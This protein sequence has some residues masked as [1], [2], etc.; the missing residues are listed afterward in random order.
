M[1]S[2]LRTSYTSNRFYLVGG[3][4]AGLFLLGHFFAPLLYI[5]RVLLLVYLVL[6]VLDLLMIYSLKNGVEAVRVA[7]DKLSNGDDNSIRIELH[8][9]YSF[10]VTGG[11]VDEIP[12]QFQKRD[13][14]FSY[15]IK[16]GEEKEIR[17]TLHPV[18]R[19]VYSFGAVNVFAS[20]PVGFFRR[21]YRYDY[22]KEVAV[23]PSY[24]Q[25]RKYELLA[26]S[27]QLVDS[28]IKKIRRIGHNMEFEQI[29]DYVP[30]DDFRTI[31]W[32][33][34]ARR[35]QLMVNNYTDER[36]QHIYA[37]IDKGR[38]MKSP[39]KGMTL[40]DYAINASLAITNIA[41]KKDDK[42]GLVTYESTVDQIIPA[43][44]RNVQMKLINEALYHQE[45][46]FMESDLGRV[47]VQ[48]LRK[49]NQ[50]SLLLFFTNFE[51]IV[52]MERQLSHLRRLAHSHLVV[53]IFFENTE[54]T[55]LLNST[56]KNLEQ[57]YIK[58]IGE[59]FVLEKKQIVKELNKIGVHAVLTPPE[60][61]TVQTVNKY[62]ELK[63]RGLI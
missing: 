58:T 38:L 16:A 30:G 52:S 50:R 32:K 25:M 14:N 24:I 46:S 3:A 57:V 35:S 5:G 61:L 49:L 56:P 1:I 2:F 37:V 15:S 18:K 51:S 44:K 9:Y 12:H 39:F 20:G 33:A 27:N 59:K 62:L 22:G 23:Y 42:A 29:K 53:C 40:L 4:L 11:I 19:G 8:N 36:S 26:I 45:T 54:L 60:N 34:T 17:Y 43:S 47:T 13:V 41:I 21:R 28:G 6:I 7:P 63:A 31:N 10:R 55:G 48:L